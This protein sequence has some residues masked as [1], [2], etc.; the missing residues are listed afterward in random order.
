MFNI[1]LISHGALAEEM[2]R[3]CGMITGSTEGVYTAGLESGAG[4][5]SFGERLASLTDEICGDGLLILA[6]LYGG[7]PC[8]TAALRL[9]GAYE[10]AEMLTGM[11]LSMV[12]EALSLREG[13]LRAAVEALKDIGR[14]DIQDMRDMLRKETMAEADE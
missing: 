14:D 3:A 12:I 8:N 1:L 2:R 5:E 13:S 6:D 9:L 11:N 10:E 4:T 7:T